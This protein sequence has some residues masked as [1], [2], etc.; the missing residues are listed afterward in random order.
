MMLPRAISRYWINVE[1][2]DDVVDDVSGMLLLNLAWRSFA[3]FA[4]CELRPSVVAA[5]ALAHL[6]VDVAV[7]LSELGRR[8]VVAWTR[9]AQLTAEN[10][11]EEGLPRLYVELGL[12]TAL[13]VR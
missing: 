13:V 2:G 6:L 7:V 9:V 4:F 8:L 3:P 11:V 1:M 10:S 12:S 5:F